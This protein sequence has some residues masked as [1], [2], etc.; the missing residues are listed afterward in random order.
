MSGIYPSARQ[1]FLSATFAPLPFPGAV[2]IDWDANDFKVMLLNEAEY[3]GT[4][5]GGTPRSEAAALAA[6]KTFADLQAYD[7]GSGSGAFGF[8]IRT[9]QAADPG[10]DASGN[11][12][13]KTSTDGI[14]NGDDIVFKTVS[15]ALQVTAIIIYKDT[16]TPAESPTMCYINSGTGFPV[17][18]NG[19]DITLTWDEAPNFIFVL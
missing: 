4:V 17:T 10:T 19:G 16:G 14:A 2:G 13:N 18:P 9:S 11:I 7:N 5:F 3:L 12:D 1:L 15:S 8:H 6:D